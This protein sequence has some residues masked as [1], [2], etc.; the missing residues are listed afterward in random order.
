MFNIQNAMQIINQIRNPQQILVRMGIPQ[1]KMQSPDSVAQYLLNN[2]R[3]SQQQ[4]DQA[5][6]LYQQMFKR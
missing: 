5:K 6:T 1:D 4:I 3:I 2:G